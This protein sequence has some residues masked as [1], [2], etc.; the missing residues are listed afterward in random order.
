MTPILHNSYFHKLYLPCFS[1]RE[2]QDGPKSITWIFVKC[3]PKQVYVKQV[4]HFWHQGYN[5][6]NLCRGPLDEIRFQISTFRQDL[7]KFM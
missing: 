3:L 7:L 4:I 2:A 5:L 1:E 6:T